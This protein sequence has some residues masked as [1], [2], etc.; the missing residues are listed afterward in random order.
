MQKTKLL[1]NTAL[2]ICTPIIAQWFANKD[3]VGLWSV[4][5]GLDEMNSVLFNN[6]HINLSQLGI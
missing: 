3:Q 4:W 5:N 1:M 2:W 6:S